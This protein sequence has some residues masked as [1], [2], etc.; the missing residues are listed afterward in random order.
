M[1]LNFKDGRSRRPGVAV[2]LLLALAYV[3]SGE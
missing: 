1:T 2:V 3:G